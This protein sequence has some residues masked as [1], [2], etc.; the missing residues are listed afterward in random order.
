MKTLIAIPCGDMC[1]TGF[2]RSL[3][4]MEISG[5]VQFT[6]AQGSLIYDARN[7]L[8]ATAVEGG[9]E[10]VLWLDS[11][12]AFP[13]E[14]FMQLQA[15]LDSGKEMVSGLYFS[16]KRPIH[17]VAYTKMYFTEENGMQVPHADVLEAWPDEPFKV[18]AVGF[19]VCMMTTDL[20]K[21]TREK[22]G[23]PFSPVFGFG[24]DLSFCQR[25]SELGVDIWVDPAMKIGHIGQALFNAECY[26]VKGGGRA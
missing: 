8:A 18:A 25:V 10:R 2:L 19:G 9:F 3:V 13:R 24:E 22:F 6:F 4:G 5:Q 7:Q 23:L 26:S 12:M 20:L 14:T 15:D 16:R 17:P 11:D 1:H 21:R